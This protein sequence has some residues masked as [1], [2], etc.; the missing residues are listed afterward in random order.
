MKMII[1]IIRPGRLSAVK[2]ALNEAGF[3]GITVN[4]V[5][6]RGSQKGIVE[7]YRGSEYKNDLLDKVEIKVVVE[8]DDMDRVI[9][10]I[11]DAARTS[12]LGDGKIFVLNVEQAIRIRTNETGVA[13]LEKE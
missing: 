11:M 6:G 7:H 5:K 12:E 3:S 9:K 8:D 1:A 4:A 13:A 2:D 10:I